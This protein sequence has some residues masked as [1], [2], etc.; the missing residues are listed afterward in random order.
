MDFY[1]NLFYRSPS[2]AAGK[3]KHHEKQHHGGAGGSGSSKK[4]SVSWSAKRAGGITGAVYNVSGENKTVSPH[5]GPPSSEKILEI[6]NGLFVFSKSGFRVRMPRNAS[7]TIQ[8]NIGKLAKYRHSLEDTDLR[9]ES[10][11][12]SIECCVKR[13][14]AAASSV[15]PKCSPLINK[16]FTAYYDV[17]IKSK[18]EK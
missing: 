12:N 14:T 5:T 8:I 3:H 1:I 11:S 9:V 15:A 13:T 4:K 10:V 18:G 7:L 16:D 2:T 17:R 6:S